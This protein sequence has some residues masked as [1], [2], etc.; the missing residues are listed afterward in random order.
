MDWKRLHM[1]PQGVIFGEGRG[2][3]NGRVRR[4][5]ELLGALNAEYGGEYLHGSG[6]QASSSQPH[7]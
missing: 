3:P 7:D 1:G 2:V 5:E 4:L 6:T